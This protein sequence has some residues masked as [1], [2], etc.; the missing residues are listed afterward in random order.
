MSTPDRNH[1]KKSRKH[2]NMDAFTNNPGFVRNEGISGGA[3]LGKSYSGAPYRESMIRTFFSA[4]T[5]FVILVAIVSGVI[6]VALYVARSAE[7]VDWSLSFGQRVLLAT[8]YVS[9]RVVDSA[10]FSTRRR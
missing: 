3:P 1:Q 2:I 4:L 6:Y 9:W 10:I 8:M 5:G 7:I